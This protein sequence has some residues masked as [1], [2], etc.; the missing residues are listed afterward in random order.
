MNRDFR[1]LLAG[2]FLFT[3]GNSTDAFLILALSRAGVPAASIALL[4]SLHH[5]VKIGGAWAG[6]RFTDRLGSKPVMLAAL[7]LYGAIY[8]AFGAFSSAGVLVPVFIAYGASIGFLE[9][10]EGAMVAHLSTSGARGTAYGAYN[11]AKGFAALPASVMF[12][13]VWKYHGTFAAFGMG[14][15]LA[16]G[17]A[18]IL[19]FVRGRIRPQTAIPY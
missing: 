13:Y 10:A 7:C 18:V 17:S 4:W 5:I 14:A 6:G 16:F 11:A 12:G 19:M 3:L 2:I 15:A 1:V 8:L 9:P